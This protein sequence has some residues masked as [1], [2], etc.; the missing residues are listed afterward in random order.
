M[1]DLLGQYQ[2]LMSCFSRCIDG[3]KLGNSFC[4]IGHLNA[5]I[6]ARLDSVVSLDKSYCVLCAKISFVSKLK[7]SVQDEIFYQTARSEGEDKECEKK[8]DG[9]NGSF[10]IS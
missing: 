2:G 5:A 8:S 3:G 7:L 1:I 10:I 9:K 4:P 6:K